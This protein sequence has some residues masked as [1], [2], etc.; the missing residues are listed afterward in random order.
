MNAKGLYFSPIS[1]F[2]IPDF[3]IGF[4]TV[5]RWIKK[6]DDTSMMVVKVLFLQAI[7]LIHN[8]CYSKELLMEFPKAMK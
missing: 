1:P 3:L 7:R 4:E 5:S 8:S 2:G 6:L